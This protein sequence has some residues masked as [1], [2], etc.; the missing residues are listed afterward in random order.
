MYEWLK[1][2]ESESEECMLEYEK[3]SLLQIIE[4]QIIDKLII[5]KQNKEEIREDK[6]LKSVLR[7]VINN[8][9]NPE[10]K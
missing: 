6:I 8:P 1:S 4:E 7:L 5:D 9:R 2:D 10:L 3:E